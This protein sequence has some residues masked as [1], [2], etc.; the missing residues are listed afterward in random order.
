MSH[1]LWFVDSERCR[2]LVCRQSARAASALIWQALWC[3]SVGMHQAANPLFKRSLT[4][5]VHMQGE[6]RLARCCVESLSS[7]WSV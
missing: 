4:R 3:A 1:M 7:A 2:R 5:Y 6:W